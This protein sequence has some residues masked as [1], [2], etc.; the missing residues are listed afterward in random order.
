MERETPYNHN[1]MTQDA[2]TRLAAA[3]A[4]LREIAGDVSDR[5]EY[6]LIAGATDQLQDVL[7]ST[8]E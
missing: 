1:I 4:E 5:W 8:N 6:S 3:I 2:R 7:E